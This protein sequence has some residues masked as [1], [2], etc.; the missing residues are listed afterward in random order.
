MAEPHNL[1]ISGPAARALEK[2]PDR[3]AFA[4][5]EFL[6]GRLL[7]NP[8]RLGKPLSGQFRGLW[9]ARVQDYRIRYRIE[10]ISRTRRAD[11]YRPE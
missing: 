5:V 3:M 7:R 11:A 10:D 1:R 4:V 6:T 8:R 9:A 2:L